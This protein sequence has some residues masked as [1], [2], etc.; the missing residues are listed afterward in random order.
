[1]S[2][3]PPVASAAFAP[4]GLLEHRA[5]RA[6]VGRPTELAAIED[7]IGA[8]EAGRLS[9][10][11]VEGEPGIG[12]TRLLLAARE[13]AAARGFLTVAVGADEELRGPFLLARS[14]VGAPEV[15]EAVA[16]SASEP[17]IVAAAEALG[18][19]DDPAFA[20]MSSDQRLL[21][22]FDLATMAVRSLTAERPLALLIDDMQWADEDSLRLFRYV[23]RTEG[24]S[25]I[26]V[27]FSIR[28]EE[29][30]TLTE[31]VT[32]LADMER[33]RVIRRL[34]LARF[35][36]VETSEFLRQVL[37]GPVDPATA[38]TIHG[39][40]E[41]VPF[42][43]EEIGRAYREAGMLQQVADT[44]TLA[45]NADRLAPSAVRTLIQ[46]R[47]AHL[48]A[49]TKT[50][51]AEAALLGRHFSLKD[52]R[53]VRMRVGEAGQDDDVVALGDLMGSAVAAG[54][55]VQQPEDAPADYSFPHEQVREFAADS[56]APARRREIHSAIVQLLL[57]GEPAPETLPL[58]AHHARAAGDAQVCVRFSTEAAA[59]ALA[60]HAPEE[61]LRVVE[62]AL[63]QAATPQERL[64]LLIARD[65]ALAMLRR[66]ADRL[67]G[68]SELAALTEALRDPH[69]DLD[70]MLRRAAALRLSEQDDRAAELASRVRALA[71]E[72]DD[73]A[74]ELAACMELG[75]A[76]VHAGLGEGFAPSAAEVDLDAA[77][78]AY[79]RAADL[80]DE[81][82]DKPALAA[83]TREL[84][85]IDLGR[86]RA[87]FV[88]RVMAGEHVPVMQRVAAG[89]AIEDIVEELPI[90]PWMR[91]AGERLHRSLA[92]YE[93]LGDR[94]GIMA[95]I[96]A[97][98]Y[99]SWAPDIHIGADSARHIEE[100]RRLATQLSSFTSESQR[101]FAEVQMLYGVHVFARA[102]VIPDLALSR[103]A[104]A[105]E[106][107][108]TIGDR[109]LEFLSAGGTAIS[110]QELGDL[111]EAAMWLDRAAA[112]AAESPTPSR[113]RQL[114]LW[115]G[116]LHAARGDADGMREHLGRAVQMATEHGLPSA[117]CEALA[118]LALAA[119]T[120]GR[121]REDEKL[122]ALAERSASEAKELLP[123]L[124]GHAPWGAKAD[125]ALAT[126][127]LARERR[128]EAVEA[129]RSA[130]DALTRARHEDLNL[131]VVL[132]LAAAITLAGTDEE[133]AGMLSFLRL[134]STVIANRV[135]DEG[136]RARWFRGPIGSALARLADLDAPLTRNM[137]EASVEGLD[138]DDAQLL[139]LVVE[140]LS[141]EEIADRIAVDVGEVTRRLATTYAK[142]GASSR[143][144]A[145][146]F[147]FQSRML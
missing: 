61:V 115:R 94:Q 81:L 98:A 44:W 23:I 108:R 1:M 52:L 63:P 15:A 86:I 75:Q 27:M 6:L 101:A 107:A 28:P 99:L 56:L 37:G 111:D 60:A 7:A 130:V 95:S 84:G 10:V 13:I 35:S 51:L 92:L 138:D 147:A 69:L 105:Y 41:G 85:V 5:G 16:G 55:L 96:I 87:W 109:Q 123:L 136:V 43:V 142:I 78:E 127:A 145:T 8:A 17:A 62:I 146:A 76:L 143:A 117:R 48:P 38:S 46:R 140:G 18:G 26:F 104:D 12:K 79:R 4:L 3:S 141:N 89:E 36:V 53:E 11:T 124:P 31:A 144:D 68:L 58:L 74:A 80:A 73:R 90:A 120:L 40:A 42:I 30:A 135:V 103:G 34:K 64:G 128:Y 133:R 137:R 132:P 122:L 21:R 134:Q 113:A 25:P 57:T 32:L 49:Q 131:D 114:E 119:A 19:R 14:V 20:G 24:A 66:P 82:E 102:K 129:A 83:V 112:V 91:S 125:A 139:K 59:A 121:E 70:V 39:Q 97:M 50:A 88:E 93:E 72:R 110:F 65:D 2:V 71:G 22:S 106:R 67:E 54:L 100:I 126:V 47:A 29:L 9:A 116:A 118:A 45:R 77:E 33:M